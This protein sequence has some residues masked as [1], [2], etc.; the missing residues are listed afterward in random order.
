MKNT[1]LIIVILLFFVNCNRTNKT[2][3]N[4]N[5]TYPKYY[6]NVDSVEIIE[7]NKTNALRYILKDSLEIELKPKSIS[8][9]PNTLDSLQLISDSKVY[10]RIE[11]NTEEDI[12]FEKNSFWTGHLKDNS[13]YWIHYSE[14]QNIDD[15]EN[16]MPYKACFGYI[17]FLESAD[18]LLYGGHRDYYNFKLFNKFRFAEIGP[19]VPTLCLISKWSEDSIS[20]IPVESYSGNKSIKLYFL[21]KYNTHYKTF[22]IGNWELKE[23]EVCIEKDGFIGTN[24][25]ISKEY[26]IFSNKSESLSKI[27][28]NLG[29]DSKFLEITKSSY[30]NQNDFARISSIKILKNNSEILKLKLDYNGGACSKSDTL[31]YI[32]K[33]SQK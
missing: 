24:L 22:H 8:Y 1:I 33:I 3:Q 16:K 26:L 11:L 14:I 27:K 10:K 9:F 13:Q 23:G 5:R 6:L 28:Y 18:T 20:I 17:N 29:L 31:T 30:Y 19:S 25:E 7:V 2:S 4:L 12:N 21:E 32:K 15:H